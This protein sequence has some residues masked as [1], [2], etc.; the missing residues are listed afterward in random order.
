MPIIGF[1][2]T[3]VIIGLLMWAINTYIPMQDPYK[4]ILNVVVLILTII[5][6]FSLFVP[7]GNFND[8]RIG[9]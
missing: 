7:L 8:F 1:I 3:L 9:R 6:I 5:W 2:F 4:S